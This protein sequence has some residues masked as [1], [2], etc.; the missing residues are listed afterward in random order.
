MSAIIKYESI[1]RNN[2]LEDILDYCD[3]NNIR[4]IAR[5][6]VAKD[7]ILANYQNNK[8]AILSIFPLLSVKEL[9]GFIITLFGNL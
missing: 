9:A 1:I 7:P 2:K 6:V 4:T 8:F 3:N 5:I